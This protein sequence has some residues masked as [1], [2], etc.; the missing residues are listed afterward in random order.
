M[1][2]WPLPRASDYLTELWFAREHP[3]ATDVRVCE[4]RGL[5]KLARAAQRRQRAML[6]P[7]AFEL[8]AARV[9]W[10]YREDDVAYEEVAFTLIEDRGALAGGQWANRE[11]WSFRAPEGQLAAWG[12][13]FA[14]V[15]RSVVVSSTW[16]R[17]EL[18][19]QLERAGIWARVRGEAARLERELAEH[20]AHT[21]AEILN[22]VFLTLTDQEEYLDPFTGETVVGTSEL[23]RW[24]WQTDGGDVLYSDEETF[25]PNPG[26]VLDRSDWKR[27]PVRPR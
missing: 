14:D 19:G 7:L 12:P 9:R 26:K 23:G 10:T 5:P 22:D 24:R 4:R 25:D 20:R 13:V 18:Q 27:S 16:L 21:N 2:V 1:T 6:L 8:D 3:R 17:G 11:T 15:L